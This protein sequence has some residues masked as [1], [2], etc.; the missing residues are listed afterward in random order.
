MSKTGSGYCESQIRVLLSNLS[1]GS[2][3]VRLKA[4]KKFTEYIQTYKP[5]VNEEDIDYLFM[6]ANGI[7]VPTGNGRLKEG[8]CHYAGLDSEK[9]DGKLKRIA[10]PAI[11]LITTLISI[12]MNEEEDEYNVM[13]KDTNVITANYDNIFYDQVGTVNGIS[14]TAFLSILKQ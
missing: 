13:K 3:N 10:A 7:Q 11:E 8:L 4:I 2:H 1:E 14:S 5:D 12:D 9:H 6:G